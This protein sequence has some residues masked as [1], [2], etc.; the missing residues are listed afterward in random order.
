MDET[1][2]LA[3]LRRHWEHAG[4]DQEIAHE[5]YHEDAVLEFPQSRER[6]VGR[7]KLQGLEI[8]LS[9]FGRVQEQTTQGPR[10][11]MGG[12]EFHQL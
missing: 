11:S 3:A 10:G 6:F 5:I 9:G 8:D 4:T 7:E 1:T 12:G 2:I